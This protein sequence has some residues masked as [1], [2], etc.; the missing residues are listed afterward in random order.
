[1]WWYLHPRQLDPLDGGSSGLRKKLRQSFLCNG[2][3]SATQPSKTPSYKRESRCPNCQINCENGVN[4]SEAWDAKKIAFRTDPAGLAS[5][6]GCRGGVVFCWPLVTT[7][8]E[9]VSVVARV[10]CR[11]HPI[12][13]E[14]NR[15]IN[16]HRMNKKDRP[17]ILSLLTE[18]AVFINEMRDLLLQ[19]IV[20]L[21][22]ELVH[23]CQLPVHHLE[24]WR[25][26]P[27]LLSTSERPNQCQF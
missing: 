10:G 22:Q 14:T 12:K 4:W 7:D 2:Q 6:S 19:P 27:L 5:L 21:H 25:L 23:G 13:P 18:I 17:Y 1:M 3:Q 15:K 9:L 26:F 20:L 16:L 24:P 8:S 11:L